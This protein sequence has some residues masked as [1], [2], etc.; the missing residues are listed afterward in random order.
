[1]RAALDDAARE[2]ASRDGI[3][4]CRFDARVPRHAA[5]LY[6]RG[7]VPGPEEV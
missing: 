6:V 3:T 2:I 7:A 5:R 4:L 1:M